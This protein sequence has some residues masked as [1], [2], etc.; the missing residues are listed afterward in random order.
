MFRQTAG[1]VIENVGSGE[2]R[3]VPKFRGI[4]KVN[5]NV[6]PAVKIQLR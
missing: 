3:F 2:K 4:D 6:Q 1:S 5:G